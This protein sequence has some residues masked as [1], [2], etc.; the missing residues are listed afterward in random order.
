MI[1]MHVQTILLTGDDG[2]NSIGTRLLAHFLKDTY[3]LKIAATK[4]QQSGM[5]GKINIQ[6]GAWGS[7]LVEGVPALWVDGS[8]CDAV[9]AAVNHF[10]QTFDLI[11]SGINLGANVTGAIISSGTFSAAF[12]GMN[13]GL[14]EHGMAMSWNIATR[15][16]FDE[17]S[18]DEPLD[19]FLEY[20]G[21]TAVQIL[22]LAIQ[23]DFWHSPFL[24]VN[25]PSD[26]PANKVVFTKPLMNMN[27]FF[28]AVELDQSP[29]RFRYPGNLVKNPDSDIHLDVNA[30]ENGLISITP[31]RADFLHAEVYE[32]VKDQTY[33]LEG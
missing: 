10:N 25:F 13:L 1:C 12:R 11:L 2:Y 22:H 16:W 31:S 9:E 30:I 28:H 26:P 14:S 7:T 23:N 21:K 24:N 4:E 19:T 27:H 32:Q 6:G 3:D 5:G 20:P 18:A 29:Q 8:P 15:H 33:H 17:H